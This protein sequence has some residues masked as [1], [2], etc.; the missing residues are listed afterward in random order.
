[1]GYPPGAAAYGA[2]PPNMQ[3]A[4][5]VGTGARPQIQDAELMAEY[6]RQRAAVAA[7]T[8]PRPFGLG[9]NGAPGP[10]G[11][12]GRG[13]VA[14]GG[15]QADITGGTRSMA[16]S[17]VA[18]ATG[19]RDAQQESAEMSDQGEGEEGYN[20]G[21]G[22]NGAPL[23]MRWTR[24]NGTRV[25]QRRASHNAIELRRSRRIQQAIKELQDLLEVRGPRSHSEW[26]PRVTW[27]ARRRPRAWSR[28]ATRPPSSPPPWSTSAAC[29]RR[30]ATV[31]SPVRGWRG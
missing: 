24:R 10:A 4:A 12:N 6:A 14:A 30:R 8:G 28:S 25:A 2:A 21:G 20:E 19:G 5:G 31:S 3:S 18:R 26:A 16:H 1:M 23:A 17:L 29:R 7:A 27:L 15:S 13:V 11:S 9:G 22:S